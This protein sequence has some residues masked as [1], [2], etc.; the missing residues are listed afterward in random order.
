MVSSPEIVLPYD[1]QYVGH[2]D[3]EKRRKDVSEWLNRR[4]RELDEHPAPSLVPE[5]VPATG[6]PAPR[7][8]QLTR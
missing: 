2:R 7:R 4:E 1:P 6:R 3:A 8:R 5:R